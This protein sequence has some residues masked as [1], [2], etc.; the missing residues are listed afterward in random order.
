MLAE[1]AKRKVEGYD[2]VYIGEPDVL[3][4]RWSVVTLPDLPG[5]E[6]GV[7]LDADGA[8]AGFRVEPY[9]EAWGRMIASTPARGLTVQVIRKIR[10]N[11]VEREARKALRARLAYD[12]LDAQTV[13]TASDQ[14]GTVIA[15][16]PL[17]DGGGP[18]SELAIDA[19]DRLKRVP[20]QVRRTGRKGTDERV[21]AEAAAVYARLV[22]E[23][24]KPIE[25]MAEELTCS[26]AQA[27][28]LVAKAREKSLLTKVGQ[29][30]AGGELTQKAHDILKGSAE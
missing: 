17:L 14:S 11:E 18:G 30:K 6:V 1:L 20:L 4:G 25:R 9:G 2:S 28:N 24:P 23:G 21:Y 5:W 26:K 12:L 15:A 8:L 10:L 27:R 29:G 16:F 3:G 7:Y 22:S 19:E 13:I